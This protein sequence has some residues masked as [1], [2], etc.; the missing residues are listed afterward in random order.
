KKLRV[1][2]I[3]DALLDADTGDLG[4]RAKAGVRN[5]GK[6]FDFLTG[7]SEQLKFRTD[8][9]DRWAN[10]LAHWLGSDPI[11]LLAEAHLE[12]AKN[13]FGVFFVN[14]ALCHS[15]ISETK[16]GRDLLE[17][18]FTDAKKYS[19]V[20]KFVLGRDGGV[21][22]DLLQTI[23]KYGSAP[24]EFIKEHV[25][26]WMAQKSTMTAA[27]EINA[28][29]ERAFGLDHKVVQVFQTAS[30]EDLYMAWVKKGGKEE[31]EFEEIDVAEI[32]ERHSELKLTPAWEGAVSSLAAGIELINFALK[33]KA[34][35]EKYKGD[36]LKEKVIAFTELVG[37]GLDLTAAGMALLKVGSK[38][39]LAVLGF[40]SAAIDAVLAGIEVAEAI[41]EGNIGKAIGAGVVGAGSIVIA[42]GF[43]FEADI[44]PGGIF[45]VGIGYMIKVMFPDDNDYQRF[46]AHSSFGDEFGRGEEKPGWYSAD[47]T[48]AEWADDLDEQI[49]AAVMLLCK[50]ELEPDE[51][52]APGR[53]KDARDAVVVVMA[54]GT[55]HDLQTTMDKAN[56]ELRTFTLKMRWLPAGAKL[57]FG[58][59][60]TWKNPSDTRSAQGTIE[61]TDQAP[62]IKSLDMTVDAKDLKAIEV[63]PHG[64]RKSVFHPSLSKLRIFDEELLSI[65]VSAWLTV[66]MNGK[67]YEVRAKDAALYDPKW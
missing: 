61:F 20:Q 38:R 1:A 65:A 50:F 36:E 51:D 41:S 49:H 46:V 5:Q 53:Q 43:L 42:A 34:F 13:D 30:G 39:T 58:Y 47:K 18:H 32:I 16:V 60:E 2:Q 33:L 17:D 40:A 9:R 56:E 27:E 14:M 66:K 59:F 6:L 15:R 12:D 19:W 24:L 10:Y 62:R 44:I 57:H 63:G 54:G 11:A 37:A 8:W 35:E 26:V 22:D 4:T 48:F 7:Y 25:P 29:I 67:E 31:L 23:R 55:R 45:I 28:E 21:S 52:D 64:Q 3:V